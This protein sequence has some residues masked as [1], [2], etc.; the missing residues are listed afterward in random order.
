MRNHR[1]TVDNPLTPEVV[2]AEGNIVRASDDEHPDLFWAL[3]SGG[4]KS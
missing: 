3:R 4:G 2:T 1:L